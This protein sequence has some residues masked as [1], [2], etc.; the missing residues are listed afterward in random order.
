MS[1]RS[2]IRYLGAFAHSFQA[3]LGMLC[4]SRVGPPCQGLCYPRSS[5]DRTFDVVSHLVLEEYMNS[6]CIQI[7]D[8]ECNGE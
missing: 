2:W 5:S 6:V 4:I 1:I 7:Q 3:K 8:I